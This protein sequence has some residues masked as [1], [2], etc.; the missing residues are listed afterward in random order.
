MGGGCQISWFPSGDRIYWVNP[1]GNNRSEIFS[2]AVKDGKRVNPEAR[3][4]EL[5][6]VDLP[7]R[8]SHEYFPKVSNDGKWLVWCATIYGHDHD[9]Y[10]YEVHIWRVGRPA[11]EAVRLTFHTGNDRWPDIFIVKDKTAGK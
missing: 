7:G 1:T 4:G 9:I 11:E 8:R 5:Q 10:D 6:W 2:T 3:R